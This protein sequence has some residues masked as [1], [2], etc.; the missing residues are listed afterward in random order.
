M[1]EALPAVLVVAK[2]GTDT[3][4]TL[5]LSAP[6]KTEA[7]YSRWFPAKK[8]CGHASITNGSSSFSGKH[9]SVSGDVSSVL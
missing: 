5:W 9:D 7:P 8:T 2:L 4:R 1:Y 3:T 6:D